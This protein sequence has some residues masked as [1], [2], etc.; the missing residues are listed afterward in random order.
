LKPIFRALLF[1]SLLATVHSSASPQVPASPAVPASTVIL[2][3]GNVRN[4]RGVV[5]YA[6]FASPEGWPDD[7][8]K[9]VR[10]GSLPANGGML[11]FTIAGLPEGSYGI[12]VVHDE[13]QNHKLDKDLL[14]RPKEG[15]G[16]GAN[17][18][19]GFSAPSW[20]QSCV[21]VAGSSVETTIDLRYP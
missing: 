19:I 7:K 17:P 16:F 4:Q 20:K 3:V 2:K 18:K 13:N 5:R 8:S 6:V 21:R 9:A 1:G 12:A 11:T 14:G 10:W 15:I